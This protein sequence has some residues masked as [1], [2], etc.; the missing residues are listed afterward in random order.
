M[1][2]TLAIPHYINHGWYNAFYFI[3]FYEKNIFEANR[4]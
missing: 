2:F 3:Y 4:L 1:F